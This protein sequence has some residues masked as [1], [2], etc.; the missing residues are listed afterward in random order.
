M[1]DDTAKEINDTPYQHPFALVIGRKLYSKAS[2]APTGSAGVWI[3]K[4]KSTT[5]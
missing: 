2:A 3:L 1:H 5:I 4:S